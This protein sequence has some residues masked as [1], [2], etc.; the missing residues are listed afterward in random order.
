M[1]GVNLVNSKGEDVFIPFHA[2]DRITIEPNTEWA[3]SEK[4]WLQ[5]VF[6]GHHDWEKTGKWD[7]KIETIGDNIGRIIFD[8]KESANKMLEKIK[9]APSMEITINKITVKE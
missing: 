6:G 5:R 9:S 3:Y 4:G 2:I 7:L 1:E 8:T